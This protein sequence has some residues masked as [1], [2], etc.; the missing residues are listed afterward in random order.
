MS[1][2]GKGIH[3]MLQI[4]SLSWGKRDTIFVGVRWTI[5]VGGKISMTFTGAKWTYIW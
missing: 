1:G 5:Y 4:R 2:G 3:C